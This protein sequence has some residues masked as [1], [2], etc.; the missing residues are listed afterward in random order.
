M[1]NA[2]PL[3]SIIYGPTA[4]GKSALAWQLAAETTAHIVS[5]DARQVYQSMDIVTGK[6]LP[7]HLN[8]T[9]QSLAD[10]SEPLAVWGKQQY[11]WG[12]DLVSPEAFFS[13]AEF[14]HRASQVLAMMRATGQPIILVG[15]SWPYAEVLIDPPDSLFV[16]PLE[17]KRATWSHWSVADLQQELQ[18][19]SPSL[20]ESLAESDRHN[21]RRLIRRLEIAV[22]EDAHG[23]L[24]PLEPRIYPDEYE[25]ILLEPSVEEQDQRMSE[26]IQARLDAGALEETKRLMREYPDWS[27]T[28]FSS[29]GYR[30]LRELIEG[31]SAL[32]AAVNSWLT[33]ERQYAKRQRTWCRWIRERY[34]KNLRIKPTQRP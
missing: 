14:Y 23:S 21:P 8:W 20:W 12:V 19:L 10:S 5:F 11:F 4:S 3:F 25:I 2:H 26:R 29:T 27:A 32:P 22:Y 16:P 30:E 9:T 17:E 15:G 34:T 13:I 33:R 31:K 28:S 7:P 24:T 18:H 6:D 1:K